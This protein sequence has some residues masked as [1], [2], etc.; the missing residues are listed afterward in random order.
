MAT[1]DAPGRLARLGAALLSTEPDSELQRI[2][3]QAAALASA[4]IALVSLVMGHVQFFRASHGL[5]LD[6]QIS[7]ATSREDSFCQFVV[8]KESVF[9]VTN[10][11][12]D[13]RLPKALVK[14]YGIQS[15]VG[16]PVQLDGQILGSLCVIDVRPRTFEESTIATL[17]ELAEQVSLR[18]LFLSSRSKTRALEPLAGESA[19][20]K[21]ETPEVILSRI[22]F[23]TALVEATLEELAPLLEKG[24]E[25]GR[26]LAPLHAS[27]LRPMLREATGLWP[28]LRSAVDEIERDSGLLMGAVAGGAP[29]LLVASR[30]AERALIEVSPLVRLGESVLTQQIDLKAAARAG[31]VLSEALLFY[32]SMKAALGELRVAAAEVRTALDAARGVA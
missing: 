14:A 30:S 19:G 16:L 8:Q 22:E 12:E 4:P 17:R 6:L 32:R 2:V 27:H 25:Y 31:S 11:S 9:V 23:H 7:C 10:A 18:L 26:S 15:Y 5:P 20:P 1:L 29:R 21:T 28:L 13:S 3:A 24:R